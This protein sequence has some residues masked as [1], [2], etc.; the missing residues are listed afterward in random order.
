[1]DSSVIESTTSGTIEVPE[2]GSL[3]S[4]RGARWSVTDVTAQSL[5]RSS[6]DD[7]RAELQHAVTMQSVEEDHYGRELCVIWEL[8]PGRGVVHEQGLPATLDP[9]RQDGVRHQHC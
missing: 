9:V 8:E 6:A 5:P 4:V 7:G 2:I 1:M 3:V